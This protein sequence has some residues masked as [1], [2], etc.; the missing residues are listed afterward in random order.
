MDLEDL[1]KVSQLAVN[2]KVIAFRLGSVNHA[3]LDRKEV[4]EFVEKEGLQNVMV[5]CDGETIEIPEKACLHRYSM[6][7]H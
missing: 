3:L 5:P 1:K 7:C 4:N 2:A 6:M